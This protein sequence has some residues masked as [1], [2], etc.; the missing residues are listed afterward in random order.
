M[1]S[2]HVGK[3]TTEKKLGEKMPIR[4]IRD[5]ACTQRRL[6]KGKWVLMAQYGSGGG[7]G[8]GCGSGSGG[9]GWVNNMCGCHGNEQ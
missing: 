5:C 1:A 9:G 6:T 2:K 7:G 3:A 4:K 8:G